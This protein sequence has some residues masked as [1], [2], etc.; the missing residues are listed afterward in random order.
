MLLLSLGFRVL[1]VPSKGSI[2]FY[3]VFY[4]GSIGFWVQ[5]LGFGVQGALGLGFRVCWFCCEGNVVEDCGV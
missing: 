3:R 2:G 5:G 4:K 1:G